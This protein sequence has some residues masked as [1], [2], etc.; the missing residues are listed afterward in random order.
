MDSG[1]DHECGLVE[2]HVGARL[3]GLD[4]PMVVDE[5]EVAGLDQREVFALHG[6]AEL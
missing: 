4:V 6:V 1:V 3:G 5:D 2:E